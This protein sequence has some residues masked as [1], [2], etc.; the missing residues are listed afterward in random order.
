[1]LLVS[2]AAFWLTSEVLLE[3][4]DRSSTNMGERMEAYALAADGIEDNPVFGFG[5][6][7]FED[8]FRLY[9]DETLSLHFNKAHNTYLENMFELGWPAALVQFGLV[10]WLAL[11]CLRGLR[12][13]HRDWV[14][15]AAGLGATTLVALHSLVD[16][17]LQMPATALAYAGLMGAA[18]AQSYPGARYTAREHRQGSP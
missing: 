12:E 9:R 5:Y 3:R 13:R 1:V 11:I 8:S 6:G 18:V 10:A 7:T 15:P 4:F 17:S 2:L 14:F 16:F